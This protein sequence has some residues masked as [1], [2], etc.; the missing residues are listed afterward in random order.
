MSYSHIMQLTQCDTF[1]ALLASHWVKVGQEVITC[2]ISQLK[3]AQNYRKWN[4]TS[5]HGSWHRSVIYEVITQWNVVVAVG[6]TSARPQSQQNLHESISS[7]LQSLATEE[8][9]SAQHYSRRLHPQIITKY[10]FIQT[11]NQK[12]SLPEL[13]PEFT[14]STNLHVSHDQPSKEQVSKYQM[15]TKDKD[16]RH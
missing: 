16:K 11:R 14:V 15:K 9:H 13:P 12:S 6:L 2:I 8:N 4:S 1:T 3:K 7:V 10:D 5:Y